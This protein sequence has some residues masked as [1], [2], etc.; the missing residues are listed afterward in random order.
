MEQPPGILDDL[1]PQDV[2]TSS[3]PVVIDLSRKEKECILPSTPNNVLQIIKSPGWFTNSGVTSPGIHFSEP[4]LLGAM[5]QPG[6]QTQPDNALSHTT[7]TLSYMSR[8]HVFSA[9]DSRSKHLPCCSVSP[10]ST[11]SLHPHGDSQNILGETSYALNQHYLQ[12]AEEPLNLATQTE[13]FKSFTVVQEEPENNAG[14]SLVQEPDQLNGDANG[15]AVSSD[16]LS[17]KPQQ[18]EK[19]HRLPPKN[20]NGLE[21]SDCWSSSG[22]QRDSSPETLLPVRGEDEEKS[23]DDLSKNQ[24]LVVVSDRTGTKALCSLSKEY[25]SPLEDPISPFATSLDDVEDVFLLP[26]TSGS[27]SATFSYP[28]NNLST[29]TLLDSGAIPGSRYLDSSNKSRQ[30]TQHQKYSLEPLSDSTDDTL[31]SEVLENKPNSVVPHINGNANA[32]ERTLK[33]R[34]LPVRSGRGTRLEAIVMN[35]NSSR[36]KVSGCIL[37]NKRIR[38]SKSTTQVSIVNNPK[39]S[40]IS[41]VQQQRGKVKTTNRKLGKVRKDKNSNTTDGCKASPTVCKLKNNSPSGMLSKWLERSKREPV[42]PPQTSTIKSKRK[43]S[44]LSNPHFAVCKKSK[45]DPYPLPQPE[46]SVENDVSRF[47]PPPPL[48]KPPKNTPSKTQSKNPG[49]KMK[50][51]QTSKRRRKKLKMSQLSSMFSPKEPEIKL[52]YVNYK[53]KRD[54]KPDSFSPFVRVQHQQSSLSLCTVINYAEVVKVQHKKGQPQQAH[55][56][57]FITAAVPSTSCL[58]LGRLSMHSQHQRPLVCC[59]CGWSANAMDLGDLH[60]PYYPE[61]YRLSPK[62]TATASGLK[63]DEDDYSDSDSSSSSARVRPWALMQGAPLKHRSLLGRHKWAGNRVGNPAAKRAPSDT[64]PVDV[65]DWYNPPVLPLEPCEY[66]FHEDCGIWS[67]GVFLVK[68]KVYGLEEAVK[69]AQEMMCSVCHEPGA[70][71]GCFFKGCGNKYHY[72][73]AL[74]SG[75]VLVEENFS[76]KCRKHKNKTLKTPPGS[77]HDDS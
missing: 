57:T 74:E 49:T 2:A 66:W 37:A 34:K 9:D 43:P 47:S 50:K 12:Q 30:Q 33:E 54:P 44:S 71:L 55:T 26:Q 42:N 23:C 68:G 27:H 28:E 7:V 70:S 60:G 32:L 22:A 73:C 51:A 65:A 75:C 64:G 63:E 35:I 31:M 72:R 61:G 40:K 41:S 67:A 15:H 52:K 56:N 69:V 10:I 4:G 29:Y 39:R 8:P 48:A 13:I 53:E 19:E 76:M 1:H 20:R 36:Y 11:F 58:R 21:N 59:F 6:D 24:N 25:L 45:K 14:G 46:P 16:E 38:V 5:V 17:G 18:H 77:R 62:A 3:M